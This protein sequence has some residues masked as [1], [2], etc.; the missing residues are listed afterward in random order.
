VLVPSDDPAFRQLEL[1]VYLG[2]VPEELG[3]PHY[4]ANW[5]TRDLPLHPNWRPRTEFPE[6]YAAEVPAVGPLGTVVAYRTDT[7]H[8]GA[9][10]RAPRGARF[11][12]HVNLRPAAAEWGQRKGWAGVS[13]DPAWAAFVARASVEQLRAF[14]FP[15]PGH[16]MWSEQVLTGTAERYPGFDPS[17]WR[18]PA[19]T[20]EA[21]QG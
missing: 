21:G 13:F 5:R 2:D 4:V 14:G 11:T 1:F 20:G 8:R 12:L 17:P 16:P 10:L 19:A 18:S 6:L 15:P 3:P 9:A 7:V